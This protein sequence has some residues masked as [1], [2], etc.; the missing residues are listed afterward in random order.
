M[1]LKPISSFDNIWT[2]MY[3]MSLLLWRNSSRV[4]GKM[5][6]KYVLG[7]WTVVVPELDDR[8]NVITPG[9]FVLLWRA[10][11]NDVLQ[12]SSCCTFYSARASPAPFT[13]LCSAPSSGTVSNC[14]ECLST[15]YPFLGWQK[16]TAMNRAVKALLAGVFLCKNH[17]LE[18]SS[19]RARP[20]DWIEDCIGSGRN[21][22]LL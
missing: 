16:H 20:F 3:K 5:E 22:F 15:T 19:D 1:S 9:F 12:Y 7:P 21:C 4:Q 18:D 14:L 8:C 17:S 6:T 11:S 13:L 2:C 10:S